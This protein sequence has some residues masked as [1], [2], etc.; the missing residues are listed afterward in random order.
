VPRI[1]IV[2][3]DETLAGLMASVLADAGYE[4]EVV[5]EPEAARGPAGAYDLV[6]SDYLAPAYAPGQPWPFLD[7][8][9]ALSRRGKVLGC[10]GHHDALADEPDALGVTA[11]TSKPF[12]VDQ[13]VRVVDDLIREGQATLA[14]RD[15]VA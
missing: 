11:V 9:R 12:D 15:H 7:Q 3:D 1:L 10:T 4:S 6:V 8:L 14:A 13:L 2:E 5:Q